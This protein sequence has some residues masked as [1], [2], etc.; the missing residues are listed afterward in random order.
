M[1]VKIDMSEEDI[2][3]MALSFMYLMHREL[4]GMEG[5]VD[6]PIDDLTKLENSGFDLEYRAV[7][8]GYQ[9]RMVRANKLV[10]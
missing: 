8:E 2:Y 7:E 4:K 3:R 10:S 5:I 9:W 6:F 1:G